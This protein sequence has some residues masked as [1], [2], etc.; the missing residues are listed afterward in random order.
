MIV[1]GRRLDHVVRSDGGLRPTLVFLHEGL[2]SIGLWRAFPD[3]VTSATGHRAILYSRFGHGW[4]DASDDARPLDFVHREALDVLPVLL[5]RLDAGRPILIGH[6]DGASIALVYAAHF[7]VSGLVLLAPHVFVEEEGLAKIGAQGEQP[8]RD[9]LVAKM[10]KHHRD[11]ESTFKAWFDVWMHPEFKKWNIED[12]LDR[13]HC[14]V[15]LIQGLDDE[16]GTLSQVDAI[17]RKLSGPI[18]RLA[19]AEC[20]HSPHLSQPR[21]TLEATVS[22][23]EGLTGRN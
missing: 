5:E 16:Y 7:D 14:P 2:G 17:E 19:L 12:L 3:Q 13:I 11:P 8:E 6:S 20:G 10:A 18:E 15:L 22:F 9:A 21:Q 4:S 23:I 1:A